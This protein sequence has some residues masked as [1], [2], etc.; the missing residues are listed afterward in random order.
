MADLETLVLQ[1]LLDGDVLLVLGHGKELGLEDDAEGAVSG[2]LA[3]AVRELAG[4]AGLAIGGNDLDDLVRVVDNYSR[5]RGLA[6]AGQGERGGRTR[7][8]DAVY[9]AMCGHWIGAGRWMTRGK[10]GN[11]EGG[12]SGGR[13]VGRSSV[14]WQANL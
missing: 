14:A 9:R 7:H 4:F 3:V 5:N 13:V 12:T 1:N 11:G 8:L 10:A 6:D 2:D